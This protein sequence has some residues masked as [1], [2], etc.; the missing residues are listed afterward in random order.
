MMPLIRQHAHHYTLK[1]Q[2]FQVNYIIKWTMN[3]KWSMSQPRILFIKM[4]IDHM[5]TAQVNQ[6][7]LH[8][9]RRPFIQI[10]HKYRTTFACLHRRIRL[11]QNY[12]Y[13]KCL[14]HRNHQLQCIASIRAMRLA[15]RHHQRHTYTRQHHLN[16]QIHKTIIHI[17]FIWQKKV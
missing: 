8:R 15:R 17:Q 5:R 10:L 14:P 1:L 13:R 6:I 4:Y 2:I 3:P 12:N 16:D 7:P 11:K 9:A